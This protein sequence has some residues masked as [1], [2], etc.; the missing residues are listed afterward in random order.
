MGERICIFYANMWKSLLSFCHFEWQISP[1]FLYHRVGGLCLVRFDER[2]TAGKSWNEL[3][4]ELMSGW[5]WI[6]A[7]CQRWQ[8]KMWRKKKWRK[9]HC[10]YRNAKSLENYTKQRSSGALS[11]LEDGNERIQSKHLLF[12]LGQPSPPAAQLNLFPP[13]L[14]PP[15]HRP[16]RPL[17]LCLSMPHWFLRSPQV[18]ADCCLPWD[19]CLIIGA[20]MSPPSAPH[21]L[22]LLIYLLMR[23]VSCSEAEGRAG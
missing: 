15:L 20:V 5:S 8:K 10:S 11:Q 4:W 18:M 19:N 23:C 22:L 3:N 2:A 17:P 13:Q 14:A 7:Q 16:A 6:L 21:P 12:H 1:A 9:Q